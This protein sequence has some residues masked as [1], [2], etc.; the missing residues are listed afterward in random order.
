MYNSISPLITSMPQ[1]EKKS[2]INMLLYFPYV[3][4]QAENEHHNNLIS[5]RYEFKFL[6]FICFNNFR[7]DQLC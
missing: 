7:V 5:M 6:N 4:W 2:V 3:F 1:N